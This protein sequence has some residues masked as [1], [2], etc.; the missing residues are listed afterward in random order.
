LAPGFEQI[1]GV[2]TENIEQKF[3][4][5]KKAPKLPEEVLEVLTCDNLWFDHQL[6]MFRLR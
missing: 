6:Q 2:L 4:L 1:W 5:K 3:L